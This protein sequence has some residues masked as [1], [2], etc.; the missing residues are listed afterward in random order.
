MNGANRN[1]PASS[2]DTLN[3]SERLSGRSEATCGTV[4]RWRVS[5]ISSRVRRGSFGNPASARTRSTVRTLTSTSSSSRISA[6]CPADRL[7][8]RRSSAIRARTW[9]GVPRR[10]PGKSSGRKVKVIKPRRKR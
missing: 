2:L 8:S 4:A 3:G 7:R 5:P 9:A 10:P 1:T 6:I